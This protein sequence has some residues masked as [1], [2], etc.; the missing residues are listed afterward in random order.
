MGGPAKYQGVRGR[1]G[2]YPMIYR[3]MIGIGLAALAWYLN[4]EIARD[5]PVRDELRKLRE[6][7]RREETSDAAAAGAGESSP[8]G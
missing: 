5:A 4:R 7:R 1:N 6:A 8:S 3:V 2:V